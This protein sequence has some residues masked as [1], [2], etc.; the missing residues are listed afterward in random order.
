[1]SII[2]PN[3]NN[4]E[5]KQQFDELVAAT[6]EQA[7]YHIWS[8]NEGL[9]IDYTPVNREVVVDID[10]RIEDVS[11]MILNKLSIKKSAYRSKKGAAEYKNSST[12][13]YVMGRIKSV[14][15]N[16]TGLP[17]GGESTTIEELVEHLKFDIRNGLQS[18]IQKNRDEIARILEDYEELSPYAIRQGLLNF[19]KYNDLKKID[20]YPDYM[21]DIIYE[22]FPYLYTSSKFKSDRQK[23]AYA[24]RKLNDLTSTE[25]K[26]LSKILALDF[27]MTVMAKAKLKKLDTLLNFITLV[28]D[29]NYRI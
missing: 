24:T 4:K 22:V 20:E 7:A 15:Y 11:N 16:I 28:H 12:T 17:I 25:N 13:G 23:I 27:K 26:R 3:F 8:Q 6:S 19:L 14:Y 5:V 29:A 9:P 18:R 21:K 1:M 2:C 10:Q